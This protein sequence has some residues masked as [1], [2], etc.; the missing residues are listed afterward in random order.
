MHRQ[1]LKLIYFIGGYWK[2]LVIP[3]L[4]LREKLS[5]FFRFLR[6]DWNVQHAHTPAEIVH[7]NRHREYG[8]NLVLVG[9]QYTSRIDS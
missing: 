1:R 9:C 2:L 8:Q 7:V 4:G 6:V 5:L 3:T